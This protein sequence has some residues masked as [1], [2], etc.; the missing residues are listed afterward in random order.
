[1]STSPPPLR[2][3]PIW[4]WIVACAGQAVLYLT[5]L[6]AWPFAIW[7]VYGDGPTPP[8]AALHAAEITVAVGVIAVAVAVA[9]GALAGR[10]RRRALMITEFSL[11]AVIAGLVSALI[12]SF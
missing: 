2:R 11:G 1:M 3:G 10:A 7:G 9:I 6:C 5:L 12:A 8:N 4:L